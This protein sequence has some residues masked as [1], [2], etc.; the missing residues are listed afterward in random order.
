MQAGAVYQSQEKKILAWLKKGH[1]ISP[2]IAD[3][4]FGCMR[5]GARIFTL[6]KRHRIEGEMVQRGAKR[7][8]EFWMA[9]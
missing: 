5:L 4:K 3:R 1:R 6:K 2:L 9:H 7:F 8:K